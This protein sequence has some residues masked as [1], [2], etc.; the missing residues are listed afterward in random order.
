TE[1][2]PQTS[3]V[4]TAP[5]T[6]RSGT[7]AIV[8]SATDGAGATLKDV[9]T[10]TYDPPKVA[11]VPPPQQPATPPAPQRNQWAV[12]IGI[13]NYESPGIPRLKY[14]VSDAEAIY[15]TLIGPAGFKKDNVLLLTDR[16][17][18]KPTLR[19][20]KWALGTFL[21]RSAQKDDTVLVY[22]AGHGARA[23]DPRGLER[24]GLAKYL[25]PS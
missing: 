18:R 21:G 1:K 3:L 22:F 24:D 13:G 20:I 16:T 5:I 17:D 10:V 4:L 6:L 8:I 25:I 14:T 2:S 9:R 11:A 23:G 7:N 12:V 15:Q 19:N